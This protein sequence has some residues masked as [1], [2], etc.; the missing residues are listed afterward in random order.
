MATKPQTKEPQTLVVSNFSG[1]L[2]RILNGDI[3]SGYAK[4]DTTF[5]Y[6]PF[7]K[8]MNLTWLAG[9]AEITGP[10]TGLVVDA[11]SRYEVP[12]SSVI[13]FPYVYALTNNS[14]AT[15]LYKIQTI[16][17]SNPVLSSV[18]ATA[19]VM[20]GSA[21]F[22]Q[23]GSLEFF[24]FD[25]KI[26]VG[27]DDQ[28]NNIRFDGS[29][30]AV[31]A[32]ASPGSNETGY[33]V[34]QD[35][36]FVTFIGKLFFGNGPTIA[37][38]DTTNTVTSSIMS[39][40]SVL[41]NGDHA[42]SAL[43]PALPQGW[44]VRDIRLSTDFNYLN[45]LASRLFPD[46]F[47]T[48]NT[49]YVNSAVA[50][51]ALFQWNSINPGITAGQAL[52]LSQARSEFLYL[53]DWY[54]FG[55]DTLGGS[56][57]K[58]GQKIFTF[59]GHKAPYR[60]A[61]GSNGNFMYWMCVE[62]VQTG[63]DTFTRYATL[64]YYGSLDEQTAP[65]LYRLLRYETTLSGGSIFEV[66]M[67]LAVTNFY[68]SSK[69]GTTNI[70]RVSVPQH[71]FSAYAFNALAETTSNKLFR[72]SLQIDNTYDSTPQQ[73]VYETQTQLFSKRIG[74]TQMRVYTEP[75]VTNNGFQIDLIGADGEVL[76]NGTFTYTFAAGSD[77]TKLQGALER[78]NFN[79]NMGT[80]YALGVRITNTGT[81][82]MT[83][84]K[85]EVDYSEEGK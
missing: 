25:E 74:V 15:N 56:L 55:S 36:P 73:G 14:G 83:I 48:S 9:P 54:V 17:A 2:T 6:D 27:S 35:R 81:A 76:D 19:S 40:S 47:A 33:I 45:I 32:T 63:T 24:Q 52:P 4:F 13:G 34:N 65:G 71:Y 85:I 22:K 61:I 69:A 50:Q 1:R 58:N 72:F 42:A 68:P 59:P 60:N 67:C 10:I 66:P 44:Y 21:T 79:P 70:Q 29:G 31:I 43:N 3:N 51:N 37:A 8:P 16:S 12:T 41:L 20:A 64:Y 84:K 46:E 7:S 38:I 39:V 80:T 82:N 23:G 18:V 26:Y 5:G 77:L 75:T 53:G 28:V 11:K 62:A 49:D 57:L 30:D 78:I